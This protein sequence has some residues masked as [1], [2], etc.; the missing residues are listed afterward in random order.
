ML[1]IVSVLTAL[2]IV[3][4]ALADSRS[5]TRSLEGSELQL[6]LSCVKAVTIDPEPGLEGKI[7]ITASAA[8]QEELDR[9]DFNGGTIARVALK[10][11]CRH[12][13]DHPSLILAIKVPPA[14][15]INLKDAGAGEYTIGPVGGKLKGELAGA[16][17]LHVQR[18][19]A[20]E[21]SSAGAA[22]IRIDQLDGPGAVTLAGAGEV[23]IGG[24]TMPKLKLESGGAG[25]FNVKGGEIGTLDISLAGAGDAEIHAPVQDATLEIAGIGSIHVDKVTG[26]VHRSSVSGIG[27]IDIGH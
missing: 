15:P 27:S 6:R 17:E 14:T 4:P 7:E 2:A 26:T 8:R 12:F 23:T 18:I 16:G 3:H 13:L 5:L 24:G 1:R 10:D 19:T 21:L 20:L 9:L 25:A 11:N 22:E